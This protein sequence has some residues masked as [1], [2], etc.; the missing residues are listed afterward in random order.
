MR[1]SD[2]RPR[3]AMPDGRGAL[4]SE[5]PQQPLRLPPAHAHDRGRARQAHRS[6]AHSRQRLHTRQLALA[7]HHPSHAPPPHPRSEKGR[8]TLPLRSGG[9]VLLGACRVKMQQSSY[10]SF[11][12][13]LISVRFPSFGPVTPTSGEGLRSLRRHLMNAHRPAPPGTPTTSDDRVVLM[14]PPSPGSRASCREALRHRA[15]PHRALHMRSPT[16]LAHPQLSGA[17]TLGHSS[18]TLALQL[19]ARA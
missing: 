16:A 14:G 12:D 8:A 17:V 2:G 6:V 13:V 19:Q 3:G 5:P 9:T 10:G 15:P 7:H 4:G 18:T 1:L 11:T